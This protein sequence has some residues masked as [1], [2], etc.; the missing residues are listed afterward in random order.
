MFG[1]VILFCPSIHPLCSS[2]QTSL[3]PLHLDRADCLF[4]PERPTPLGAPV[5]GSRRRKVGSGS[6]VQGQAIN[7]NC[8]ITVY[9]SA[10]LIS[11]LY[12]KLLGLIQ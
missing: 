9:S 5:R 2:R 7:L 4:G 8:G 3:C 11:H 6:P 12:P 10:K 1:A